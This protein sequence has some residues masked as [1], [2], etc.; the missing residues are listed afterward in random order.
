M[1]SGRAALL[2]E[3]AGGA[4]P[5]GWCFAVRRSSQRA[6][7]G[8]HQRL[9]SDQ[10]VDPAGAANDERAWT[11]LVLGYRRSGAIL[12]RVW[13]GGC[14][15]AARRRER[16]LRALERPDLSAVTART[17]AQLLR[18]RAEGLARRRPRHVRVLFKISTETCNEI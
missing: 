17:A 9:V 2:F 7:R 3:G 4:P 1:D 11:G 6:G 14:G 16:K 5:A 10:S 12:R 8:P 18:Y 13:L 15:G